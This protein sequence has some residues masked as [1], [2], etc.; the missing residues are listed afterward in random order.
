M[1]HARSFSPVPSSVLSLLLSPVFALTVCLCAPSALSAQNPLPTNQPLGQNQQPAQTQAPGQNLPP[2]QAAN[3]VP[4]DNILQP[5]YTPSAAPMSYSS[6]G[7]IRV[8]GSVMAGTVVQRVPPVYPADAK[9]AGVQ[10]PVVVHAEVERDGTVEHVHA[11]SG[12]E[13][14][15][16]AAVDAV[17]HWTFRPY[18]LNGI[19]TRVRTTIVVNFRLASDGSPDL[20]PHPTAAEPPASPR[21]PLPKS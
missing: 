6:S 4:A 16:R 2:S 21:V 1:Q 5:L 3:G 9:A 19:P 8:S 15:R 11:I 10:G 14:L 18:L 12:P 7:A 17:H 20:A 13:P